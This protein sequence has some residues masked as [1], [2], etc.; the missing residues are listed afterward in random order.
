L[1]KE[2]RIPAH[3][4]YVFHT[5]AGISTVDL[6]IGAVRQVDAPATLALAGYTPRPA[7]KG[8][9]LDELLDRAWV[10]RSTL[11]ASMKRPT[12]DAFAAQVREQR[13]LDA[14]LMMTELQLSDGRM[15]VIPEEQKRAF[16]TDPAI[17]ALA[18]A[19]SAKDANATQQAVGA[20]EM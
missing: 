19:V 3:L 6:N 20:L 17:Q 5:G 9:T 12:A 2:Q 18:R 8:A 7:G 15:P 10:C 4:R 11:A 13:P 1:Q 14:Y 16:Q